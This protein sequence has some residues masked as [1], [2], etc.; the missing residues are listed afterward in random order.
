MQ[1]DFSQL[2]AYLSANNADG[3]LVDADG[4]SAIQRYLS[5]FDAP[6]PFLSV[7][8]PTIQAILV[9]TLEYGRAKET[10]RVDRVSRLADFDYRTRLLNTALKKPKHMSLLS[11]FIHSGLRALRY[12]LGFHSLVPMRSETRV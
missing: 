7:Y 1:P 5:G 10:A 8:T 12:R 2:D 11:G 3:Y 6:D 9:S 4:S